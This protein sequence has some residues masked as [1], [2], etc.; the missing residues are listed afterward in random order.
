MLDIAVLATTVVAQF[1]FPFAKKG[2]E[3]L[4]E[5]M[6]KEVGSA[7][8]KAGV[9]IATKVW[10]KVKSVFSSDKEK[11]A[12]AQFEEYPDEA[13]ALVERI[14]KDKLEQDRKLAE[15][16]EGLINTREPG[17]TSTAAQ[18]MHAGTAGIADLRQ[19]NLAG[20]NRFNISGV[21]VGSNPAPRPNSPKDEPPPVKTS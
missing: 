7:T 10:D 16:L 11:N 13:K 17:A 1:L 20:A 6:G 18:I 21:T 2:A 19:A 8:A 14:L 4:A 15:E 5:E 3:K 9:N 12:L